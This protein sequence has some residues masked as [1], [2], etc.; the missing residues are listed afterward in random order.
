M[1]KANLKYSNSIAS[2]LINPTFRIYRHVLLILSFAIVAVNVSLLAYPN[3]HNIAAVNSLGLLVAYL[4]I[5]YLNLYV[6]V[7]R[8]LFKNQYLTYTGILLVLVLLLVLTELIA[9]FYIQKYFH[10]DFG[11]FSIL[12]RNNTFLLNI[13]ATCF[14]YTICF[15]GTSITILFKHWLTSG[16]QINELERATIQT[17]LQRLKSKIHPDFLFDTLEKAGESAIQTPEKTSGILIKLSKFLRYQLYDSTRTEVILSSEISSLENLL[18]LKKEQQ[19]GFTYSISAEGD[20]KRVLVPPLLFVSIVLRVIGNIEK[21][22]IASFIN[23]SFSIKEDLLEFTCLGT[24]SDK[25]L[26]FEDINRRL[27]LIFNE[28]YILKI[29]D[30]GTTYI[31]N[32]CLSV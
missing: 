16:Q 23:L 9:E 31:I 32:L 22:E 11:K 4:G 7:P 13:I 1:Q 14:L 10:F 18:S 29:R 24:K 21:H 26:D 8:Y 5:V 12:E 15:A 28:N 19:N 27:E 17:E 20:L 30:E 25:P 3:H 6:L 2:F